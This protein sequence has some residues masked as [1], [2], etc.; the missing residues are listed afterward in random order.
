[1]TQKTERLVNLTV[2]F[3]EARRPMTFADL[4]RRTG[5][6]GQSDTESAR[7]MFERDK[8]DLR[9]LGVPVEVV[10]VAFGEE[11][12]YRV[13]RRAYEL[14]DVDLTAEEVAALA[15]AVHLTGGERDRLALT[16]LVARAPDPTPLRDQPAVRVEI[17]ADPVDAVADA[18]VTRTALAFA[19]RA[20]DGAV[21]QRT[22]DP[23]AIVQRR[24]SWYLVARDH[25]R[26]AI[27]AFRLDRM[28]GRPTTTGPTH[29]FEPPGDLDLASAVSGPEVATI[30]VELAVDSTTRWE[31]ES[32]GGVQTGTSHEGRAVLRVPG[33]DASRD[34]PWLLGLWPGAKVL[35]P[36]DVARSVADGLEAVIAAHRDPVGPAV[37][38]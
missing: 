15:L 4:K 12:G 32:R 23:Y 37:T 34:R 17:A 10:D 11:L 38:P 20:A 26:R 35:A 30:D 33:I 13:D 21:S 25:A 22:V 6:Y 27:R 31:V 2:A 9:R 14:P 29:A 1:M 24:G 7:R 36:D 19:Y 3:L 16:K 28:R 18:V 5:F 8:D